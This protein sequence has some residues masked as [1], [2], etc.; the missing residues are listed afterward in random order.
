MINNDIKEFITSSNENFNIKKF[1]KLS[2]YIVFKK[3]NLNK[4]LIY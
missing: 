3:N 2:V 1:L 4:I